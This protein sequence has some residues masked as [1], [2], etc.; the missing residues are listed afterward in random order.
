M[1]PVLHHHPLPRFSCTLIRFTVHLAHSSS[2]T[3]LLSPHPSH[4]RVATSCQITDISIDAYHQPLAQPRG[5]PLFVPHG[6]LLEL[7]RLLGRCVGFFKIRFY[8]WCPLVP[9]Y[10]C[11]VLSYIC[12]PIA[13]MS[14]IL[15]TMR[16]E[17]VYKAPTGPVESSE[18]TEAR[19]ADTGVRKTRSLAGY[20]QA[21]LS[22]SVDTS[23]CRR[24]SLT[25]LLS[26]CAW[27]RGVFAR[28][29]NAETAARASMFLRVS[30]SAS[31][32]VCMCAFVFMFLCVCACVYEHVVDRELSRAARV[33]ELSF[34]LMAPYFVRAYPSAASNVI[35]R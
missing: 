5:L 16:R 34:V 18:L 8:N 3:A 15:R 2:L 9:S 17:R 22:S 30:L 31:D 1:P 21:S 27:D 13:H 29:R 4:C 25:S 7:L 6:R 28:E 10:L 35:S 32:C 24:V 11:Y 33:G 26:V 23:T 20:A 19:P 12:F 14:S